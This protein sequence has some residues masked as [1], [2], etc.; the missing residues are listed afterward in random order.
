MLPTMTLSPAAFQQ[1]R[2]GSTQRPLWR[3]VGRGQDSG[4]CQGLGGRGCILSV[5]SCAAAVLH[6]IPHA[7]TPLPT[8]PRPP[9]TMSS[10]STACMQLQPNKTSKPQPHVWLSCLMASSCCM[11]AA[12]SH[13]RH[14][15]SNDVD[16]R[17]REPAGRQRSIKTSMGLS[18]DG[19]R[20]CRGHFT[21]QCR[22]LLRNGCTS[23]LTTDHRPPTAHT[24]AGPP[25][26]RREQTVQPGRPAGGHRRPAAW[27]RCPCCWSVRACPTA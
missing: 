23:V 3:G 11:P 17:R 2:K 12:P 16:T 25:T 19:T 20:M 13:T 1:A 9:C 7:T 6:T 5:P 15:L 27:E 24:P 14:V 18:V 4:T 21:G 8:C 22:A 26:H 10:C